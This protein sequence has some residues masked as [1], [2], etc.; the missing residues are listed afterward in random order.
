[1]C[2]FKLVTFSA[3]LVMA[4]TFCPPMQRCWDG[5][6]AALLFTPKT[7]TLTSLHLK[8]AGSADSTEADR[9]DSREAGRA[10]SKET[11]RSDS[12]EAD[13]AD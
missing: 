6:G 10:D 3:L 9:A 7:S 4:V 12:N 1:M 2:Y 5:G 13:R 8:E 11:D